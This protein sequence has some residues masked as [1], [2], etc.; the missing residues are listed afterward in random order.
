MKKLKHACTAM[1]TT[2]RSKINNQTET[3]EVE[4]E[5]LQKSFLPNSGVKTQKN[6]KKVRISKVDHPEILSQLLQ[7]VE[8]INFKSYLEIEK[9]EITRKHYLITCCEVVLH[10]AETNN[11]GICLTNDVIYVFNGAYWQPLEKNLLK[12]FLG[13]AAEK[14]G[15]DRFVARSYTFRDELLKQFF[16]IATFAPLHTPEDTVLINLKNGTIEIG[17]HKQFLRPPDSHDFLTSQLP[18][19]YDANATAPRFQAYL[20]EVLPDIEKQKVLGEF[21]GYS[22]IPNQALKCEKVLLCYGDG[23]N[24]KSVFFDVVNAL[25]GR[26]N[27]SSF[28]LQKLTDREGYSR[29]EIANKLLNYASEINGRIESDIFKQLA[30][31]EPVEAR[32]PYGRP[33]TLHNYPK[34]AFNLNE[35]PNLKTLPYPILRRLLPVH[36]ACNIPDKEQN[37]GL[38][39]EIIENELPGVF[40]WVLEGLNRLCKQKRFTEYDSPINA[41]AYQKN[42]NKAKLTSEE[43][44]NPSMVEEVPHKETR[45]DYRNYRERNFQMY[46]EDEGNNFIHSNIIPT[47]RKRYIY[48]TVTVQSFDDTLAESSRPGL[49]K[50][51]FLSCIMF[52]NKCGHLISKLI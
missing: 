36:F 38:A 35:M 2:Q 41:K 52:L 44:Y 31:G 18:F 4:L 34:L 8:K 1:P 11:L 48:Y 40:N 42:L 50:T 37:E 30:S 17:V 47:T 49:I 26:E 15:V 21:I 51:F 33:Y 32:S 7:Q 29:A 25:L 20:N 24:G 28:S 16:A 10:T 23:A 9:G 14:M 39:K 19:E 12:K 6:D 43:N 5:K 45:Q 27:V 3:K 22:L 46:S 13:Q